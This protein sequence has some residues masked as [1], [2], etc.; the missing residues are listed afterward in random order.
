MFF[1]VVVVAVVAV[2]RSVLLGDIVK[3]A[4][5]KEREKKYKREN[6]KHVWNRRLSYFRRHHQN[7]FH[8]IMFSFYVPFAI[9]VYFLAIGARK[10]C[11]FTA[12]LSISR[13]ASAL[14]TKRKTATASSATSSLRCQWAKTKAF[15]WDAPIKCIIHAYTRKNTRNEWNSQ[16][17]LL[18]IFFYIYCLFVCSLVK[19]KSS[20]HVFCYNLKCLYFAILF[21]S[22]MKAHARTYSHPKTEE[23]HWIYWLLF[24]NR[25]NIT[26]HYEHK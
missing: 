26:S 8:S 12:T 22:R 5:K 20:I 3:V 11:C 14:T 16:W 24:S 10:M 6:E 7:R 18:H 4:R 23:N 21:V 15:E 1:F 17:R 2:Y 19:R 13:A 9:F 25:T